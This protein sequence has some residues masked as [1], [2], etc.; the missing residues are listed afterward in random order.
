[1]GCFKGID[2]ESFSFNTGAHPSLFDRQ[3]Q[4]MAR[5]LA[6]GIDLYGYVT[7]TTPSGHGIRSKIRA[8]IDRLQ[9]I[10][11][12]LPLRTVPLEVQSFTPVKGRLN[13][14][15]EAALGRQFDVLDAWLEELQ[16][17]FATADLALPITEIRLTSSS[18][19]LR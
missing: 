7:F 4:I 17:R 16:R 19:A 14:D 3:F 10:A 18:D 15:R 8:F 2:S 9:R 13:P 11:E 12:R 1:V 5:L 6:S